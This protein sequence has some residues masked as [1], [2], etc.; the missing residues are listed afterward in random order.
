MCAGATRAAAFLTFSNP[1][2]IWASVLD[3]RAL[4]PVRTH[5]YTKLSRARSGLAAGTPNTNTHIRTLLGRKYLRDANGNGERQR[6]RRFNIRRRKST[7]KSLRACGVWPALPSRLCGLEPPATKTHTH[8]RLLDNFPQNIRRRRRRRR[9]RRHHDQ[10][11]GLQLM[12]NMHV[13][14]QS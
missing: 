7:P 11:V 5:I 13:V 3:A 12:Y 1:L 10:D 4:E 9:R 14:R 8:T 2:T 6:R